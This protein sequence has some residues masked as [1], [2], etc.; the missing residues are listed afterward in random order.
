TMPEADYVAALLRDLDSH[1]PDIAGR[2]VD[3]VFIGGGTPSLFSAQAID[4][5]LNGIAARVALADNVEISMEANPGSAEVS[6][7]AG[8][9]AAGVNRLSLGIQSFDDT[10][11]RA[12]GRVHDSR[13]AL[14]AIGYAQRAGFHSLNLDLMHGLP[15]Q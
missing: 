3:T 6:K 9:R 4:A 2:P 7:F 13:Q 11:L 10:L 5:L 8:F 12:L 14:A 15:G 1:L